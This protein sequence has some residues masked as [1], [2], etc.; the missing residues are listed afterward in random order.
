MKETTILI[1]G[2]LLPLLGTMI[3]SAFVFMM[4]NEMSTRLQKS[5]LVL[6]QA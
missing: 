2:L 5:L 1:I 4:K 3:G 6:H